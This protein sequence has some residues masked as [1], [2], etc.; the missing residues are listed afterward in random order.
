MCIQN[1]DYLRSFL[2]KPTEAGR[3]IRPW[4]RGYRW[5]NFLPFRHTYGM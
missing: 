4:A 5:P 2:D 3:S 1:S